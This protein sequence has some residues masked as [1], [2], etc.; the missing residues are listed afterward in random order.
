MHPAFRSPRALLVAPFAV[1][2]VVSVAPFVAA[3]TPAPAALATCAVGTTVV[4]DA[5]AAN[6]WAPV[7]PSK[8]RFPGTEVILAQAGTP[9]SGP[10]RPSEYA[11]LTKGPV[12]AS[13]QVDADVRIDTPVQVAARDVVVIFGYQSP[14]KFYYVHLSKDNTIYPHNGIFLVNNADRLRID[15]QWNGSTGARPAIPDAVYHR[16]RVRH[17]AGTGEIEVYMDGATTLLMTARNTA[18]KSGRVGVGSFDY[19][20]RIRALTVTG[21]PVTAGP[22]LCNGVPATIVGTA[23][24]DTIFGTSGRDVIAGLGGRD[25]IRAGSGNDLICGGDG[26][27]TLYGDYGDDTL[28]GEAGFDQL[29]GGPGR[30]TE[31]QD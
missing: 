9:P 21:T 4:Q 31:R 30:D 20:G 11:V 29:I 2:V 13:V 12:F 22:V 26:D 16:V 17:C 23:A 3:S 24:D 10:R 19:I 15:D 1:A 25:T 28:L 8:W 14:T 18:L 5:M 27:D 7:T 6:N